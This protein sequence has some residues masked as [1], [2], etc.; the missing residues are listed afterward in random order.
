MLGHGTA[1]FEDLGAYMKS[2]ETMR[3]LQGWVGRAY[4]GHGA[5]VEEGVGRVEMYVQHRGEREREV[6]RA[7]AGQGGEKAG[8]ADGEDGRAGGRNGAGG[9][10]RVGM[11]GGEDGEGDPGMTA[12]EVVKVVYRDTPVGLHEAAERGVLQVLEKLEGE[13]RVR[14]EG[15]RWWVVER[16][17]GKESL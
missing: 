14:G 12:A 15:G 1:V 3:G 11:N 4:P 6:E 9:R 2:L 13:G 10:S 5:V 7:V 17:R 16:E 8:W